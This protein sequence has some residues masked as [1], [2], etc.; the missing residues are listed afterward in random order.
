MPVIIL[1]C[2]IFGI[3]TPT[4]AAAIAVFYALFVGVVIYRALSFAD[5]LEMLMR[6]AKITGVVF[7]IIASASILG[8]WLTFMQIPQ[9]IT[10]WFLSFYAVPPRAGRRRPGAPAPGCGSAGWPH[11]ACA[12]RCL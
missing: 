8:W 5:I 3:T 6:T 7:L 12:R 10:A 11:F 2:I 9:A 4:E 1:G